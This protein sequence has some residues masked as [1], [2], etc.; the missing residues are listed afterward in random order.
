MPKRELASDVLAS[1]GLAEAP[2]LDLMCSHLVLALA[3]RQGSKFNVRR[4]L[5]S[6]FRLPGA[7]WPGRRPC[8]AGY[9]PFWRGAAWTTTS[10]AATRR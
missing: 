10:G 9:G 4:D 7:T 8:W 2:V 6:L 5:G 3:A 1:P